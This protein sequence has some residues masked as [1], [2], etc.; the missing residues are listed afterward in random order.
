MFKKLVSKDGSIN[1]IIPYYKSA[2]ECRYVRRSPDYIS[3]YVSSHNG[4]LMGCK[5]C[6]LTA[7]GQT[8]FKHSDLDTYNIQLKTILEEIKDYP[9]L[10]EAPDKCRKTI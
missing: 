1:F 9:K 2:I 7:T 10:L 3:T 5:F 8:N 4:C 6:W